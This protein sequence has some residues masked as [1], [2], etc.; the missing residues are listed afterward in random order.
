MIKEVFDIE[1]IQKN[2]ILVFSFVSLVSYLQLYLFKTEFIELD[3]F[4][5]I[6]LSFSVGVCWIMAELP[7]YF[8]FMN[9]KWLK[10]KNKGKIVT[11]APDRIIVSFGFSLIFWMVLL[12]FIGYEYNVDLKLFIKISVIWML[13]KSI[14]WLLY[15]SKYILID[16]KKEN[17]KTEQ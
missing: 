1:P 17:Q 16:K 9:S 11:L 8:F 4:D 7:T 10:W 6:I 3:K 12:T 15:W 2:G 13:A 14:Y 5:K